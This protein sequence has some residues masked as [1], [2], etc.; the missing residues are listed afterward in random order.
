M[1]RRCDMVDHR[2]LGFFVVF[3]LNITGCLM[4]PHVGGGPVIGATLRG[5]AVLGWEAGGGAGPL[6]RANIG[7]SYRIP[8]AADYFAISTSSG[9]NSNRRPPKLTTEFVHYLVY[10]PGAIVGGTAGIAHS[11]FEGF[12]GSFGLWG[13][14]PFPLSE[15]DNNSHNPLQSEK[16]GTWTP[17]FSL[18]IGWRYIAGEHEICLFPK[19]YYAFIPEIK[20]GN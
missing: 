13:G 11:N 19:F 12:S 14:G 15:R 17:T 18:T 9:V 2:F 16:M 3:V 8:F 6:L 1:A 20:L 7:G 10:E 4:Y 5:H